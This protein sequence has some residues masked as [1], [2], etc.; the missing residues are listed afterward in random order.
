MNDAID[1]DGINAAASAAMTAVL[2]KRT[3]RQLEILAL[4]SLTAN[5]FPLQS[6]CHRK[7]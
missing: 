7:R 2:V 4:R 1:F 3:S 6:P 5:L